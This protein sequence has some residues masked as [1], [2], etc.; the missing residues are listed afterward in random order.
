MQRSAWPSS[1]AIAA[2]LIVFSVNPNADNMR[3]RAWRHMANANQ[4]NL[5]VKTII[6]IFLSVALIGCTTTGNMAIT[7]SSN[8]IGIKTGD[9]NKPG[10][11]SKFGQPHDVFDQGDKKVWRYLKVKTSPEPATFILGVLIWPL[12]VFTQTDY[13]ISQTDFSF[14]DKGA[15]FDV[16]SRKGERRMG[17]IGGLSQ[18][19][20]ENKAANA[21]AKERV[22]VE[23][24]A[25]KLPFNEETKEDSLRLF[26]I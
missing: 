14:N 6:A 7:E 26:A 15:L 3:H 21:L 16:T 11:F 19:S 8:F 12:V 23:L 10:I 1:S 5:S 20:D 22:K 13:E 18:N 17:L 25:Q 4:E 9:S 24:D 2:L